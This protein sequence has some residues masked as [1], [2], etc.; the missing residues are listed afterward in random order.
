MNQDF[1]RLIT[2]L[3]K[4]RGISQKQAAA[5]LGI[6]Q[7]LLSHY[8]KGIREC[9]L[10]FVV[11]TANFYQV[12]CDYLLGRTPERNGAIVSLSSVETAPS[13]EAPHTA[14]SK[15]LLFSSLNIIF[16]L[17]ERSES[18]A[19]VRS[20]TDYLSLS[21]YSAFRILYAIQPRNE[22]KLFHLPN[23]IC[24]A[25]T[26]SC[27][28]RKLAALRV[29]LEQLE[30]KDFRVDRDRFNLSNEILQKEFPLYSSALMNVLQHAET[31]IG[32]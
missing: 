5:E 12:S 29:M 9:G 17:L 1:P 13:E 30:K 3:R 22:S 27:Q 15:N 16:A 8:E 18:D 14:L 19:L 23:E 25:L 32:Q 24:D 26:S 21:I 10:D 7:A 6:S 4:E 2:L 31:M 11:R 28:L 20:M